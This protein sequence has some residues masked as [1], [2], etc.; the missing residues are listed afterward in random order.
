MLRELHIR[1]FALMDEVHIEFPAGF[2]VLTGE[3]GAGKSIIIK[4]LSLLLGE[5]ASIE[6]IR[7]GKDESVVEGVFTVDQELKKVLEDS[8]F[9]VQDELIIKRV[10]KRDGKG[11]VFINNTRAGVKF[12]QTIGRKLFDIHGQHQHQL[13]LD[14]TQHIEFLDLYGGLIGLREEFQSVYQEMKN[15]KAEFKNLLSEVR[16]GERK[17]EF[18]QFQIKEIEQADLN[19]GEEEELKEEW[20]ILSHYQSIAE[21]VSKGINL[22]GE[23]EESVL[24]K[25]GLLKQYISNVAKYDRKIEEILKSIDEAT[26]ILEDVMY[27]LRDYSGSLTYEPDRLEV[28]GSR[29]EL[30]QNLKKKYGDTIEEILLFLEKAK[31]ELERIENADFHLEKIEKEIKK[32]EAEAEEKA[33]ELSERRQEVARE[34]SKRI[35][36]ELSQLGF[37]SARFSVEI[38]RREM[39]EKGIDD[40]RFLF[41]PNIGEGMK[42]LS[43]IISGGELSRVML[44]M[45]SVIGDRDRVDG[46]VFDEVDA[47]IGGKTA[48]IVAKKL[49]EIGKHRQVLCITH[50]PVIASMADV[51]FHVDKVVKEGRTFTVI[52]RLD[53]EERVR[54][55]ARMLGGEKLTDRVIEHAKELVNKKGVR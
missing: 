8:G 13:L 44:A 29:L 42:R 6:D 47:G 1:N 4:A 46:L 27:Q 43:A 18:L 39:D 41:Q 38:T 21:A 19:I 14:E 30:I 5:R 16:E 40:V 7:E 51:H 12:L 49:K 54:E 36:E 48:E 50:L 2:N 9:E 35:T 31:S 52:K 15:K 11:Q 3:T 22:L 53:D 10:V 37:N 32:L 33:E 28:V 20:E 17:K 25:L 24:D 34:F 23:E 26:G 45:K 55:I